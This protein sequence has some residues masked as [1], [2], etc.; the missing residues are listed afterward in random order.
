MTEPVRPHV[1]EVTTTWPA[2]QWIANAIMASHPG[3]VA[4]PR[5]DVD[6]IHVCQVG[7]FEIWDAT[8]DTVHV[9]DEQ[10]FSGH[11]AARHFHVLYPNT[12]EPS[13][14]VCWR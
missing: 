9:V 12:A 3:A 6:V 11:E 1:V 13:A 10:T 4:T 8:D 2:R 7:G 5:E 14:P